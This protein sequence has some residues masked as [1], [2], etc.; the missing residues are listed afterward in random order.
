MI[1]VAGCADD[2]VHIGVCVVVEGDAMTVELC[3]GGV[4]LKFVGLDVFEDGCVGG[5]ES[6]KE[7]VV[8]VGEVVL[9]V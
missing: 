7:S 4:G 1:I 5:G 9:C 3:G 2:G 6:F 8:G